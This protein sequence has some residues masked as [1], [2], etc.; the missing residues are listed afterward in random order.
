[1]NSHVWK[2][3][4]IFEMLKD[5]RNFG[6]KYLFTFNSCEISKQDFLKKII[7]KMSALF[8]SIM[9]EM[10]FQSYF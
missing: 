7:L 8:S 5:V 3:E 4:I 9:L 6:T 10:A 1:M 2:T